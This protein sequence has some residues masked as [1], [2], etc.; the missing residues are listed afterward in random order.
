M[1]ADLAKHMISLSN[2]FYGVSVA[3]CRS[4]AYEMAVAN[5]VNVPASWKKAEMAGYDWY[6]SFKRRHKLAIRTPEPTSMA[7]ATAFNRTT[8]KEFFNN[9]HQVMDKYKFPPDR[10]Y[11][12]D[13]TGC[14]TVQKPKQVIAQQGQKQ[15][16]SITSGE[17]GE[18]TTVACTISASG[19]HIPPMMV[20]PR[21]RMQQHFLNGSFPGTKGVAVKNG[22]MTAEVFANDYLDH[23]IEH[24]KC[25]PTDPILLILDN[26]VSHVSIS[27]IQRAK[28]NGIHL[29]TLPPHTSHRLQP[30]DIALYGPF[31]AYFNRAM[32]DWMRSHPGMMVRITN[33]SEFVRS[34]MVNSMTPKNILSGFEKAGIYPVNSEIFQE[35]DFVAAELTDRPDPSEEPSSPSLLGPESHPSTSEVVRTPLPTTS[36]STTEYVSPSELFPVPKAAP[37]K[38]TTTGR[39]RGKTLVLTD[40]PVK[41]RL[42]EEAAER[43]AKKR[44]P[45][46]KLRPPPVIETSE[47]E[48]ETETPQVTDESECDEPP[49]ILA[50]I[51][52]Y[53]LVLVRGK[54]AKSSKK[55]VGVVDMVENDGDIHVTF[56]SRV[57]SSTFRQTE[58]DEGWVLVHDSIN[59]LNSPHMAN[60]RLIK[61]H[62][63]FDADVM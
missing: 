39:K 21:V 55:F 58:D 24:T 40:T 9:L 43:E 33:M 54:T 10:I 63:E 5:N 11:N 38:A 42:E 28:S 30:L 22:W 19:N 8:V 60:N 48:T 50:K 23:L 16:G 41:K 15:V 62:E 12:M 57:K 27:A 14:T 2:R 32:D 36:C 47:S 35:S 49:A 37:R 26:H 34:A 53:A 59:I 3:Q 52:E 51:G 61:F 46:K 44:A 20:F 1:E 7:R 45:K 56:L 29:L 4:M 18:L 25:T 13:E 31:K 17:R 6:L